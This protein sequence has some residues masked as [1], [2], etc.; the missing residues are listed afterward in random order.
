[1][2]ELDVEVVLDEV[3]AECGLTRQEYVDRI[4][5]DAELFE[6]EKQALDALIAPPD[7]GPYDVISRE[8]PAGSPANYHL[9]PWWAVGGDLW[10]KR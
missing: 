6:L 3:C 2:P 8:S 1:L 9:S 4:R 5:S 10:A 7:P